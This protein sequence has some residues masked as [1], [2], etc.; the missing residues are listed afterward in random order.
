M[1][2]RLSGV[3]LPLI[4]PFIDGG[5]DDESLTRLIAHYMAEPVDGFIVAATTG[6]GLVLDDAET[7]RVVTIAAEHIASRKPLYLGLCG[8]DTRCMAHRYA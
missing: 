6:E 2:T 5:L 4:T 1:Q 3:W 7:E 8:S